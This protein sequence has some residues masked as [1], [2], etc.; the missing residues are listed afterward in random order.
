[1]RLQARYVRP[2]FGLP[3]CSLTTSYWLKCFLRTSYQEATL[4]IRGSWQTKFAWSIQ[5]QSLG[6]CAADERRQA[7]EWLVLGAR[8]ARRMQMG[9]EERAFLDVWI[10]QV[11]LLSPSPTVSLLLTP[12]P[13][14]SFLLTLSH[15][16]SLLPRRVSLDQVMPQLVRVRNPN[17]CAVTLHR[18]AG[19]GA[20]SERWEWS[21]PI[22]PNQ[23]PWLGDQRRPPVF[24]GR[25][26][27]LI[28]EVD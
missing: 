12:S 5:A 6:V 25:G 2:P 16:F 26:I 18:V 3:C 24:L 9:G 17:P 28:E 19:V 21:Y 4:L 23:Q 22:F 7:R 27:G 14:V 1:M 15:A 13:T 20:D 10:D 8:L 11:T